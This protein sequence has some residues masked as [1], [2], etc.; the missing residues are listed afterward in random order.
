MITTG[1]YRSYFYI[2]FFSRERAEHSRSSRL[3]GSLI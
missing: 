2:V 3:V 1:T